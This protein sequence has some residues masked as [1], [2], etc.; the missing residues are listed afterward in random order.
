MDLNAFP[1]AN[2]KIEGF[3]EEHDNTF[4]GGQD[5]R[6]F[7]EMNDPNM[8]EIDDPNMNEIN[9]PNMDADERNV[10]TPDGSIE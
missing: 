10:G 6:Q 9:D 4:E 1:D 2:D 7:N 3:H 5:N 8:N